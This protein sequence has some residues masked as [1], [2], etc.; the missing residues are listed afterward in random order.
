MGGLRYLG[1]PVVDGAT[2]I[3]SFVLR[4]DPPGLLL[5]YPGNDVLPLLRQFLPQP[6]MTVAGTADGTAD[7]FGP[8]FLDGVG[9]GAFVVNP[10]YRRLGRIR[11][12]PGRDAPHGA[13]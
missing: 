12:G 11:A 9:R 3:S 10:N 2:R 8:A 7:R 5:M 13:M 1:G 6:A 4:V